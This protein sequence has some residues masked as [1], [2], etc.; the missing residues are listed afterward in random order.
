MK[1]VQSL[2]HTFSLFH[3]M[4]K[5]AMYKAYSRKNFRLFFR[6]FLHSVRYVL[7]PKEHYRLVDYSTRSL[8]LIYSPL[9][10][11][12]NGKAITWYKKQVSLLGFFAP[13]Y[14]DWIDEANQKVLSNFFSL[15]EMK[16]RPDG[17]IKQAYQHLNQHINPS[18]CTYRLAY[19]M[20]LAQAKSH[21]T[22]LGRP[23]R[24]ELKKTAR[25]KGGYAVRLICSL[26][27][28]EKNPEKV[29]LYMAYGEFL[30]LL[31]DIFDVCQDSKNGISTQANSL[32]NWESL[33]N[34]LKCIFHELT[35]AVKGADIPNPRRYMHY[36]L[37]LYLTGRGMI[38]QLAKILA[39][40]SQETIQNLSKKE[41]AFRWYKPYVIKCM[42]NTFWQETSR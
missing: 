24:E 35:S 20:H 4:G 41:F 39:H 21:E 13:F 33:K 6:P 28:M 14:D 7:T 22:Q 38:A 25:L 32:P 36:C 31:D 5:Y 8:L 19:K 30:Q 17:F 16:Q 29:G 26:T 10:E 15:E 3:F 12:S 1:M 37:L 27:G 9:I 2:G 18:A 40:P 34:E 23:S 11:T 42:W